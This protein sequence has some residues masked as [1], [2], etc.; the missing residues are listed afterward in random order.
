VDDDN[1]VDAKCKCKGL[2]KR[3]LAMFEEGFRCCFSIM[4][5]KSLYERPG[6]GKFLSEDLK[7]ANKVLR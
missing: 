3:G 5:S 1:E 4:T 7:H 6:L 2:V